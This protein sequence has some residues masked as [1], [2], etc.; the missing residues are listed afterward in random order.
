MTLECFFQ[1]NPSGAIAFSGG[2]NSS[3]LVWAAMKYGKDWHAYYM[4]SDFQP[5]FELADARKI[6]AECA[7]PLTILEGHVLQNPEVAANPA[8]RCYFCK[9]I[10][11]SA[12]RKQAEQDGYSLLIDGTTASD[13]SGDCPGIKALEELGVRSPLRECGFTK[14]DIRDLSR[15]AGLFTWN[16]PA[17][18]CLATR[19]PTGTPIAAE[20]LRRIEQGEN[21]LFSL[22]FANFRLRLHGDTAVLQLPE[23]Y[24][25]YALQRRGEILEKLSALFPI[26][27]IDLLP[28]GK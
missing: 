20:S 2:T 19:I 8:N 17:Y 3:L 22:G 13:D 7:A 14:W 1:E 16:K 24:F 10:I 15:Q 25:S 28:R 12:L 5:T 21:L 9:R 18:A 4:Y 26:V 11:F 23:E 6:A 27:A